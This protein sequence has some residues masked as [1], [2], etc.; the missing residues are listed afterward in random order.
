[1]IGFSSL[2]LSDKKGVLVTEKYLAEGV[3]LA[4]SGYFS[5]L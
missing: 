2:H 1:M 4:K 3:F 5:G